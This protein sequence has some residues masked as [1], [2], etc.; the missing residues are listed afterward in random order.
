MTIEVIALIASLISL[1][2]CVWSWRHARRH[3]RMA[4]KLDDIVVPEPFSAGGTPGIVP[5]EKRIRTTNSNPE[6]KVRVRN[7]RIN[8]RSF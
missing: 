1:T 3:L 4:R 2:I 6:K 5:T 8:R 7:S